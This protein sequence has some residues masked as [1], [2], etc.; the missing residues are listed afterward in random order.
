MKKDRLINGLRIDFDQKFTHRI[1][2]QFTT[3]LLLGLF[4]SSLCLA[5]APDPR[6]I[7]LAK[8]VPIADVHLHTYSR[9]GPSAADIVEKMNANNVRWGG[10]V[11]DL[12]GDIAN[13]LGNRHI[14]TAGQREFAE[15]FIR[16][17]PSTLVATENVYFRDLFRDAHDM[18]A[19]GMIKGFGE[20]HTNNENS[21]P[22]PFRRKIKTDN[23]V[24]R[25][26]YSIANDFNGF[27]QIHTQHNAEFTED[28]LRLSADFPNTLTILSHCLPLGQPEDLANLFKQRKNIMCELSS[29]GELHFRL[30]RVNRPGRAYSADG[31]RPRWKAVIEA[32]PDRFMLGSDMCCGWDAHYTEAITEIRTNFLPYLRADVIELIAYKNALRV[33]KLSDL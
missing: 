17:G 12:R 9:N 10:G 4:F 21:G 15:S 22:Q 5:Q 24:I 33:F 1:T 31:V 27:V 8:T 18:F 26:F 20:L 16:Q 32:F 25:K 29:N 11:G 28:I 13:A 6:S 23:P 7:E 14:A 30:A 2:I 3:L 19:K